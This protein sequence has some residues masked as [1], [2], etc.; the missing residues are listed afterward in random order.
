MSP[1]VEKK[2]LTEVG[3]EGGRSIMLLRIILTGQARPAESINQCV[4]PS[5]PATIFINI[6]INHLGNFGCREILREIR[7]I[8]TTTLAILLTESCQIEY[9]LGV[10]GVSGN[11]IKAIFIANDE[12][13]GGSVS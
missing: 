12:S 8:S 5:Q 6:L 1:S 3:R 7:F 10:V 11:P 9:I 13:W 2:S 4:G